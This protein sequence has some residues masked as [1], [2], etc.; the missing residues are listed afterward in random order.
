MD[1]PPVFCHSSVFQLLTVLACVVMFAEAVIA[2][3]EASEAPAEIY[4][5]S[6]AVQA[7]GLVS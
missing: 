1:V 4:I 2:A 7:V 3:T 5:V 6:P